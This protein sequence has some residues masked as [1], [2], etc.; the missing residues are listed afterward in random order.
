MRLPIAC[1]AILIGI[2]GAILPAAPAS[3]PAA[4]A[5]Q[6]AKKTPTTFHVPEELLK[7]RFRELGYQADELEKI[8]AFLAK[9]EDGNARDDNDATPL[10]FA[11]SVN[12]KKQAERFLAQGADVN[13]KARHDITPLMMAAGA[14][15]TETAALLIE[16]GADVNARARGDR[17]A[18][19]MAA[20]RCSRE[21]VELLIAKG[22]DVNAT[23][24]NG[25]TPLHWLGGH[26]MAFFGAKSIAEKLVAKGADP[27]ARDK[28]GLT[29]R[30]R[31]NPGSD[32]ELK[33]FLWRQEGVLRPKPQEAKKPAPAGPE[34][35]IPDNL[36]GANNASDLEKIKA[37]LAKVE[38]VKVSDPIGYTPLHW[39]AVTN[40]KELAEQFLSKGADID[41]KSKNDSTP[42]ILAA[43]HNA[44][45]TAA[46]LIEKGADVKAK[47]INGMTPLH[48]A[49]N[50]GSKAVAELLIS[51]DVDVNARDNSKGTPLMRACMAN[52]PEM[53]ELLIAKGADVNAKDVAERTTLHWLAWH[54]GDPVGGKRIAEMLIAKGADVNAKDK[55]GST[56]LKM[57]RKS[58]DEEF[59]EFLEA[60]T[61]DKTTASATTTPAT[62]PVKVHNPLWLKGI[63][64]FP[65]R[66]GTNL[67]LSQDGSQ[68]IMGNGTEGV[69]L[70]DIATG[71]P[72]PWKDP[73]VAKEL[74]S[75]GSIRFVAN[76]SG[77]G[78]RIWASFPDRLVALDPAT[79]KIDQT[80]PLEGGRGKNGL[81]AMSLQGGQPKYLVLGSEVYDVKAKAKKIE[82]PPKTSGL[83]FSRDGK[84]LVGITSIPK[85]DFLK[86]DLKANIWD[87]EGGKIVHSI[88]IKHAGFAISPTEDLI[89]LKTENEDE[90]RK[91]VIEIRDLASA[92]AKT[93]LKHS[94][95]RSGP[96][97]FS[98]DGKLLAVTLGPFTADWPAP[99]SKKAWKIGV[100]DMSS[101]NLVA[102]TA[103]VP[104]FA[105]IA[106]SGDSNRLAVFTHDLLT[107][108]MPM[109]A[110][111]TR[112][113]LR[114]WD[115]SKDVPAQW[116]AAAP[117]PVTRPSPAEEE[118]RLRRIRERAADR[119]T[120]R[121]ATAV[122]NP[123]GNPLA[124]AP[125]VNI[126]DAFR[127]FEEKKP[128]EAL[129]VLDAYE[130]AHIDIKLQRW[131]IGRGNGGLMVVG[132][133]QLYLM[134]SLPPG[135]I[136][137]PGAIKRDPPD[138]GERFTCYSTD[139]GKP[140]WSRGFLVPD[141]KFYCD[142]KTDDVVIHSSKG[143]DQS[144]VWLR[145][146]DGEVITEDKFDVT[147]LE[148]P[149]KKEVPFVSG[150]AV[151]GRYLGDYASCPRGLVHELTTNKMTAVDL[152]SNIYYS[153]DWKRELIEFH[154]RDKP[155]Y[156][157]CFEVKFFL[158]DSTPRRKQLW[159]WIRSL[160]FT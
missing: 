40:A 95:D 84:F 39:A 88:D 24:D 107:T 15:A 14:N 99:E 5:S 64:S 111:R 67:S 6:P 93:V 158:P 4:P 101:G 133:R 62:R 100:V 52:H 160:E 17:T 159:R 92:Q 132:N 135:S 104:S 51:K 36:R 103:N 138:P 28:K 148:L 120:S 26:S 117:P 155:P 30:D 46:L 94:V 150:F 2:V 76:G 108:P 90:D 21:I 16:K 20:G 8:K 113:D 75:A 98:P 74:K 25:M 55:Q 61:G 10:H 134:G 151:D 32:N 44:P 125:P 81:M 79:H 1:V 130:A 27:S 72:L 114:V 137:N 47:E 145:S 65:A 127:L 49:A 131:R 19:M 63:V 57:A 70:W 142:R 91:F 12:D 157:D 146:N 42:L 115:T 38:D 33:D 66:G 68:A 34:F 116:R 128:A 89:A 129:K 37:I 78:S 141:F 77:D 48:H 11:A 31:A 45:E 152:P 122:G 112:L 96:L 58:K 140:L 22:A 71:K 86:H 149:E 123:S 53:V 85:E 106:F 13:A 59:K 124:V 156:L 154:G 126:E 105:E 18:L 56:P 121:P 69:T 110:D 3:Q 153:T 119:S 43:R 109:G 143:K 97:A 54:A 73:D 23:D 50:S 82:L 41:A 144:V 60:K 139:D 136:P 7:A 118:A 83:A 102:I 35:V 29:P 147:T 87:V 9:I 80:I